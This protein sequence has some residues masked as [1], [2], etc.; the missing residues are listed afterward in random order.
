MGC[1]DSLFA[2]KHAGSWFFYLASKKID[3]QP[4]AAGKPGGRDKYAGRRPGSVSPAHD[5]ARSLGPIKTQRGRALRSLSPSRG[6]QR[7][8]LAVWGRRRGC[9]LSKHKG[10]W[11]GWAL[12]KPS[13]MKRAQMLSCRRLM[14]GRPP[15][16][17]PDRHPPSPPFLASVSPRGPCWPTTPPYRFHTP[18]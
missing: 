10:E 7:A 18:S 12:C 5:E 13:C 8:V 6:R 14:A 3:G 9:A 1:C 17:R 15:Q 2:S 16:D 4:R 11:C